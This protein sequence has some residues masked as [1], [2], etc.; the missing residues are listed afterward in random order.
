M[1][2]RAASPSIAPSPAATRWR[3][4]STWSKGRPLSAASRNSRTASPP[5]STTW[6]RAPARPRA[7]VTRSCVTGSSSATR[8][9]GRTAGT[10]GPGATSC[11]RSEVRGFPPRRT[12][13]S[14]CRRRGRRSQRSPAGS[15]PVR[16]STTA[17]G[18]GAPSSASSNST[19]SSGSA[20]SAPE[21]KCPP[22]SS[23]KRRRGPARS[24]F[25]VAR[26]TRLE[27]GAG[28]SAGATD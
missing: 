21:T 24:G 23:T 19:T 20:C 2:A 26:T 27:S 6:T 9:R 10:A 5:V 22:R 3:S 4:S 13:S 28:G 16:H 14:V 17:P 12:A 15:L 11:L 1:P 18:G 8:T 7:A 25:G